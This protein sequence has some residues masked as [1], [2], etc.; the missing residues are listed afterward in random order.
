M[1]RHMN[2]SR[3]SRNIMLLTFLLTLDFLLLFPVTG[4]SPTDTTSVDDIRLF[5]PWMLWVPGATHFAEGRLGT[6]L[7]FS[8]GETGAIALG[9]AFD[10]QLRSE[11]SSPYSNYPLLLGMELYNIDKCHFMRNRLEYLKATRP[12]FRY[13][14]I[15]F[16]K[17]ML[18]P[19]RPKNI[20]TP[21]TG[22]FVAVA[23]GQLYLESR[24][25]N[26]DYSEVNEIYLLNRYVPRDRAMAF[27]GTASLAASW[28]AGVG[29]EYWFR[30]GLMPIWD[31]RFGQ[32]KGLAYS[33]LLF[34]SLHL[35]NLLFEP[36]PDLK[37]ALTQAL[38]ATVAGWLLGRDVQKRDYDIGPA[39]A[40]H[41][42]YDFTLMLG[43]FLINP[44]DNIFG[45]RVRFVL[46]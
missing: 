25:D 35:T 38:A 17:L 16:N 24:H 27:Y 7:A 8:L 10:K 33:S 23:M 4:A 1:L 12:G 43:S 26:P 11:T 30:N 15:T 18:E 9:I 31:Y 46:P 28:G 44:E 19:F 20:F 29:E 45:V 34:G 22:L 40:A 39:S 13:D 5:P 21:I 42:W 3:V 37:A 36:E 2:K 14:D 41:T 32:E 6:G